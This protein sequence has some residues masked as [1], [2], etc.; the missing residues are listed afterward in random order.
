MKVASI[1]T[2]VVFFSAPFF[3]A[4]QSISDYKLN[5]QKNKTEQV[6]GSEKISFLNFE[7]A[8]YNSDLLPLFIEINDLPRNT[9]SI[10]VELLNPVFE[11]VAY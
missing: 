3:L 10:E 4:A 2:L 7:G 9:E 6:S 8:E 1:S 5:W 11:P